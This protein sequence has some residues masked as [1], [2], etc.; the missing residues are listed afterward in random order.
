MPRETTKSRTWS[1]LGRSERETA[2]SS[3]N[4]ACKASLGEFD[5]FGTPSF[6]GSTTRLPDIHNKLSQTFFTPRKQQN[7]CG[8]RTLSSSSK[9]KKCSHIFPKVF[10]T[11]G[12]NCEVKKNLIKQRAA[13]LRPKILPTCQSRTFFSDRN[14]V[15]FQT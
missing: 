5:Q 8:E 1:S 15:N 14:K 6:V 4:V 7:R 13:V 11:H 2:R 3:A 12:R 9:A 10:M